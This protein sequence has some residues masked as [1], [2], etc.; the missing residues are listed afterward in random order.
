MGLGRGTY[1]YLQKFFGFGE[2]LDGSP[3]PIPLAIS[4]SAVLNE[5]LT[6]SVL[7]TNATIVSSSML[8]VNILSSIALTVSVNNILSNQS[9]YVKLWDGSTTAII[10]H[11]T[12]GCLSI[13]DTVHH[14]CHESKMFVSNYYKEN[15]PISTTINFLVETPA[16][17]CVHMVVEFDGSTE[18]KVAFY[19]NPSITST[20]TG[21]AMSVFNMNRCAN[22]NGLT[23]IF[24]S[25]TF[26][27]SGTYIETIHAGGGN[28][29]VIGGTA[30]NNTEWV[31]EERSK[32]LYSHQTMGAGN[33]TAIT[34]QWY[35][36][37]E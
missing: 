11:E 10:D 36:V 35:E 7:R 2:S 12:D 16:S 15:I 25:C 28:R 27:S 31:L 26:S 5:I 13:I 19:E 20:G 9:M 22:L 34:F 18:G 23:K 4:G 6:S 24:S 21:T 14:L 37:A 29:G 30:R 3:Y 33:N 8:N 1:S 32:Y 17:F